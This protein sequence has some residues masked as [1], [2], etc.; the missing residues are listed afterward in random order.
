LRVDT[1]DANAQGVQPS[2]LQAHVT[3][4]VVEFCKKTGQDWKRD[5]WSVP[6]ASRHLQTQA[7][8]RR[9]GRGDV[10]MSQSLDHLLH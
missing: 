10:E 4:I 9:G 7:G 1:S 2:D 5:R 8:V 3:D 6:L